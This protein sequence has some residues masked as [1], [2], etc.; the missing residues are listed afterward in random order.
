[1]SLTKH[2]LELCWRVFWFSSIKKEWWN[3]AVPNELL[4]NPQGS[5]FLSPTLSSSL[6]KNTSVCPEWQ[7]FCNPVLYWQRIRCQLCRSTAIPSASLHFP[8]QTD[9]VQV[10]RHP[11]VYDA[12]SGCRWTPVR[13]RDT[14]D[15]LTV[16]ARLAQPHTPA[17]PVVSSSPALR[18]IHLSSCYQRS[19]SCLIH[20][21]LIEKHCCTAIHYS[22]QKQKPSGTSSKDTRMTRAKPKPVQHSFF[23]FKPIAVH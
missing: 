22:L 19:L 20:S 13:W 11:A 15:G 3:K 2:K 8:A 23:P 10:C 1:M 14:S 5:A 12:A 4:S 21:A 16:A 6:E 18:S 7:N 17:T 9:K